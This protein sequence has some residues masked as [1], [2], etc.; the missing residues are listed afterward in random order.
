VTLADLDAVLAAEVTPVALAGASPGLPVTSTGVTIANRPPTVFTRYLAEGA[1]S[2]TFFDTQLALLNPGEIP[3]TAALTFTLGDGS[4]IGQQVPVPARTRVTVDPKLIPGLAA[5]EFATRVESDRLLVVDRTMIW[6]VASGYGSHAETAVDAPSPIWYLAEG[7]THSGFEL[8]YLLQNPSASAVNV[9]VRYLLP[10]GATPLEKTYTLLP[11]SRTNIWVNLEEFDGVGRALAATDV[12]AVIET[13]DDTPIIVERA[14]YL[15]NQGRAF[16]AGHA[17]A[18]VTAPATEWFLAEGATGTYFDL[19]VLITN[20]NDDASDVTV[21]Y[22]LGDGTTYQRSF[23][24]A[25][26]SR[27]NIWVDME[28][29][30]GVPGRPLSDVAVSTTVRSTNGVPLIVERAMWWPGGS[31]TWHEAHNSAGSTATGTR[32]A[33]A[34]GEVGG[35]RNV[36][37]YVLI[38]NTSDYAGSATV[39]LLLENGSSV[40]QV[41]ELLPNS[42]TNVPVWQ[43]FGAAVEGHR[44]GAIV[45]STGAT[46]AQIVVERAMYSDADGVPWAAGTNALATRID[47]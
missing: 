17:S 20:P 19:F 44:F 1:T 2:D 14:M 8:F 35:V 34:E 4:V 39:T 30:P 37:T 16:N 12:S 32:W 47:D 23:V 5:A 6:N 10:G 13:L 29:I 33:L 40:E 43:H 24:A 22:L 9:R 42:R 25:P 36:E 45:E 26:N 18:A 31:G 41:Y 15:S 38:A 3:T 46:P 28:E 27:S 7:A 21:T 11:T